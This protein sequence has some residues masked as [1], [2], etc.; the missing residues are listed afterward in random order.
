LIQQPAGK[1][2]GKNK[3]KFREEYHHVY[4]N[5]HQYAIAERPEKPR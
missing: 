2:A 1:D 4:V 3:P 5:Q